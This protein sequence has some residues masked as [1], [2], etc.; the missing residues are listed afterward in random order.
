MDQK[1]FSCKGNYQIYL[2]KIIDLASSFRKA[3]RKSK[4]FYYFQ[5]LTLSCQKQAIRKRMA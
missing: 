3:Q 1:R 4:C 2:K 5:L